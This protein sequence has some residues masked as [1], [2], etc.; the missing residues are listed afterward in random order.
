MGYGTFKALTGLKTL[1]N[2]FPYTKIPESLKLLV[3]RLPGDLYFELYLM[4]ERAA[5]P[6]RVFLK[7]VFTLSSF[8]RGK[9]LAIR[10]L[11]VRPGAPARLAF[12]RVSGSIK[13]W[14]YTAA[15]FTVAFSCFL[16]ILASYWVRAGGALLAFVLKKALLAPG[17]LAV[18]LA[19]SL[20][21]LLERLRPEF[22]P[23]P[24][25]GLRRGFSY[26]LSVTSLAFVHLYVSADVLEPGVFEGQLL[27]GKQGAQV[28]ET[29]VKELKKEKTTF[30]LAAPG[31]KE[32]L[33]EEKRPEYKVP[34]PET[35]I[36]DGVIESGPG[37][38]IMAP[39]INITRGG[40]ERM[41]IALTFDGG[42]EAGHS[43]HL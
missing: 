30:T 10:A 2:N 12:D 33:N 24:G 36:F 37:P 13:T 14:L 1:F 32:I 16:F 40:R 41:D 28:I 29:A 5:G 35:R 17:R 21:K 18:K 27:T 43:A 38:E 22:G 11:P 31:A 9:L 19:G 20:R 39:L 6:L 4:G 3:S 8:I 7:K 23:F 42:S 15:S 26:T 34:G 25:P